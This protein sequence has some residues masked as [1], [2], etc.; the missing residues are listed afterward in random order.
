MVKNLP[1]NAGDASSIPG[2][3]T[4]IPHAC[5]PQLESL[6]AAITDPTDS[7]TK[8]PMSLNKDPACCN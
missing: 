2:L 7:G 1:S 5:A 3:G 4:K 8:G 6:C